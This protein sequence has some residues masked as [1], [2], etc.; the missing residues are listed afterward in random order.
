MM[1]SASRVTVLSWR[2]KGC[3]S[4]HGMYV[5]CTRACMKALPL[6]DNWIQRGKKKKK[7]GG[8]FVRVSLLMDASHKTSTIRDHSSSSLPPFA[9]FLHCVLLSEHHLHLPT[10]LSAMTGGCQGIWQRQSEAGQLWYEWRCKECRPDHLWRERL[11]STDTWADI[12]TFTTAS[13][14][15]GISGALPGESCSL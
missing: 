14:I 9:P 3:L 13:Q 7:R 5:L 4:A 8:L 12:L 6:R 10:S 15:K 2:S 11:R 1:L